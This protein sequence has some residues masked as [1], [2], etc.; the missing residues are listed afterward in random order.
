[1]ETHADFAGRSELREDRLRSL[2]GDQG[3]EPGLPVGP[4]C[5]V[6]WSPDEQQVLDVGAAGR[7][8][9]RGPAPMAGQQSLV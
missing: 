1:M 2:I 5:R 9:V 6:G 7:R 4:E 3:A 8:L